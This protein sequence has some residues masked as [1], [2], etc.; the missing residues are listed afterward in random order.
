MFQDL[1]YGVR[2]LLKHPG[3]PCVA[4]LMLALLVLFFSASRSAKAQNDSV[5]E[6][7]QV[8]LLSR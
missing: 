8:E 7:V 5:D 3:F 4:A 2:T 1:S 6:Y